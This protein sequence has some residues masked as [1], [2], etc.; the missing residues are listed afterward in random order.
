M[1][2]C[3]ASSHSGH[4]QFL[5]GESIIHIIANQQGAPAGGT[6]VDNINVDPTE[7]SPGTLIQQDTL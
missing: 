3:V 6:K 5:V 7:T 4:G 1:D 2:V